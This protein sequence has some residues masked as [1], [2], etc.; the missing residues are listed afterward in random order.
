MGEEITAAGVGRS[1]KAIAAVVAA[2]ALFSVAAVGISRTAIA[3]DGDRAG[4]TSVQDDRKHDC[5][6]RDGG[7]EEVNV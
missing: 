6:N 3:G 4:A 1:K 2:V 5:P 7:S